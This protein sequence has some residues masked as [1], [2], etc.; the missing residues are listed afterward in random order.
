MY[1]N[2]QSQNDGVSLGRDSVLVYIPLESDSETRVQE[3]VLHLGADPSEVCLGMGK[4]GSK[5]KEANNECVIRAVPTL[6]YWTLISQV[7]SLEHI[8]ELSQLRDKE[9]IF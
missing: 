2:C 9:V 4:R 5:E 8:S 1:H 7:D 3:Q 6:G